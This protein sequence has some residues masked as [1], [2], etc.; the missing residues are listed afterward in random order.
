M[1]LWK[2]LLNEEAEKE[3][4]NDKRV[5]LQSNTREDCQFPDNEE[6]DSESEG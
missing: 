6:A 4:S 2:A 1:D 5:L 3:K